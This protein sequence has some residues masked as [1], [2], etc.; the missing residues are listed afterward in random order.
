M[1]KNILCSIS[2]KG[3][4]DTT[5]P[6]TLA[7]LINQTMMPDKVIIFDD[8]ENPRDVRTEQHYMY[9]FQILSERGVDWEWMY[10]EK[11]GQHFNHDKANNMGYKWVWRLDDDTVP[12]GNVLETLYSYATNDVG[13][14]GGAI[15]TPPVP[16]TIDATSKISDID[17]PNIQWARIN[18]VREVDH[19]HCSFLYRARAADY[20]LGLSTIAHREETLFTYDLKSRGYKNIVVPNATTW[21]LKNKTGGIR[22]GAREMFEHDEYIFRSRLALGEC[23]PVVLDCGMGDHLVFKHVLPEVRNPVLFTCYPEVLPG[24]S[25]SEAYQIFGNLD[26]FNIY[27]K[28]D[29]WNWTGSLEDAFRRLYVK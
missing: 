26:Q 17:E 28:M 15:L 21:H 12:E 14:V 2:T 22:T 25:I 13:A 1:G 20:Y 7:A 29:K 23:T 6:M 24:R 18:E 11:R 16:V 5:L 9:V 19:L 27:G 8:N 4:Y 10:A 3:R